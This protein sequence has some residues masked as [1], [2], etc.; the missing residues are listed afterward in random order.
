MNKNWRVTNLV[1]GLM[2]AY[3][4]RANSGQIFHSFHLAKTQPIWTF[5]VTPITESMVFPGEDLGAELDGGHDHR[6]GRQLHQAD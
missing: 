1:T 6:Q 2:A 5:H 3:V 4:T